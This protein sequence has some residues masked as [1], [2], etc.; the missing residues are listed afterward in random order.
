VLL[1]SYVGL[2]GKS[3][4]VG[5]EYGGVLGKADRM[6]WMGLTALIAWGLGPVPI[7][8]GPLECRSV[9]G[10]MLGAFLPMAM[11]TALQRIQR[12]RARLARGAQS[13]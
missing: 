10:V 8:L 6:L 3:V 12:V 11:V 1:S 2:L 7:R 13:P 9:F 5:R 4:G